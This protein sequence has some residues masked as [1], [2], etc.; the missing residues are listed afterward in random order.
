MQWNQEIFIPL[1]AEL[2]L[3]PFLLQVLHCLEMIFMHNC[4]L[5]DVRMVDH[6]RYEHGTRMHQ[7]LM[8][9]KG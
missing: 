5:S 9:R 7:A 1:K 3:E 6:E 4:F 8:A 2:I